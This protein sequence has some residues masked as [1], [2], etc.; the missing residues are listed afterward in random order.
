MLGLGLGLNKY[1]KRSRGGTSISKIQNSLLFDGINECMNTLSANIPDVIS[2]TDSR[3]TINVLFKLQTNISGEFL[4]TK[5]NGGLTDFLFEL[6]LSLSGS[7][8]WY[9]MANATD[10]TGDVLA[11]SLIPL[12]TVDWFLLSVVGAGSNSKIYVNGVDVT[13]SNQLKDGKSYGRGSMGTYW[14]ING[15]NNTFLNNFNGYLGQLNIL[16]KA[17]SLAEHQSLWNS[18]CPK[19]VGDVIPLGDIAA[20]IIEDNYSWNGSNIVA[21]YSM[22]STNMEETDI[23]TVTPC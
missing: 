5:R 9:R 15:F 19:L 21:P 2:G 22:S 12:N 23:T 14:Q 6:R 20:N 11:S 1:H 16:N 10:S 4:F 3:Y 17:I 7:S 8:I 13:S 18:G